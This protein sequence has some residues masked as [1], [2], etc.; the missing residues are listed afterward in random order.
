MNR[1]TFFKNLFGVAA[2]AVVAP[3]ILAEEET[4]EDIVKADE[5]VGSKYGIFEYP[6]TPAE[7]YPCTGCFEIDM[8]QM[9]GE[10]TAEEIAGYYD[11]T[12]VLPINNWNEEIMRQK[13]LTRWNGYGFTDFINELKGS[14]G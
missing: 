5:Q 1:K 11:Q 8:A 12:G 2:A 3:R 14:K 6:M 4:F 9:P 10:M 7:S 13:L